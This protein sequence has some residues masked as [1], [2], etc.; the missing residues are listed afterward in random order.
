M[1]ETTAVATLDDL[2][3]S[4]YG[5]QDDNQ[6]NFTKGFSFL[7]RIEFKSGQAKIVK[8]KKFPGDHYALVVGKNE[9]L[10]LGET[11]PAF[12]LSY[13]YKALDFSEKGKVKVSYD[14]D[15]AEFAAIQKEADKKR[16][17]GE[18]A[19]AMYGAE[20]LIAFQNPSTGKVELGTVLCGSA[21]WKAAAKKMFGLTRK[22]V[23]FGSK[24]V[25][26][27]YT[28]QAPEISTYSGTF[29]YS[30]IKNLKKQ[31]ADFANASGSA[32]EKDEESDA[33][34]TAVRDR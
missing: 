15:S 11:F 32:E 21:S 16:P 28:Y 12:I 27:R 2:P 24:L 26:G 23:L 3:V 5:P 34:D 33:T 7:P 8:Q 13:R 25:E 20:F 9:L 29:D 22:F 6:D 19:G 17:E 30:E 31:V 4:K 14:P 10:D 18:M 1:S